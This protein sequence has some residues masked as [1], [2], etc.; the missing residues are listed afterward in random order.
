MRSVEETKQSES[1]NAMLAGLRN[2]GLFLR[3]RWRWAR[4]HCPRCNHNLHA[5]FPSY[6]ADYPD[7]PC[8][9]E[10][11]GNTKTCHD[12]TVGVIKGRRNP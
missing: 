8:L 9:Q 3:G 7:C 6:M 5:V 10:R 12:P 1:G 11:N 4:G 2:L